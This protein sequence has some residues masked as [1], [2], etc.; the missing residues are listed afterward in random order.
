MRPAVVDPLP[1]ADAVSPVR[2]VG[3]GNPSAQDLDAAEQLERN[4]AGRLV[5][6]RARAEKWIGGISALTGAL[7]TVLVLKGR[8]TV[9]EITVWGR[10]ASAVALTL[11]LFL[12]AYSIYRAYQAAY[13]QPGTLDEISPVPL[14]GLH[15]RL[16]RARRDAA[17]KALHHLRAAVISALGAVGLVALG[18]GLTW[19]ADAEPKTPSKTVCLFSNSQLTARLAGDTVAVKESAPGTAIGPCP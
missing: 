18:V 13:G 6:V 8:A 10:I 12:L 14:T 4:E 15:A 5:L 9:T 7:T 19:F 11:A 1:A 2:P 3:A 17:T 16:T